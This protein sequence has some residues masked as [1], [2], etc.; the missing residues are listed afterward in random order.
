MILYTLNMFKK[1]GSSDAST[2]SINFKI[3]VK[4]INNCIIFSLLW[5]FISCKIFTVTFIFC[6]KFE[7]SIWFRIELFAIYSKCKLIVIFALIWYSSSSFD[8]LVGG[9]ID[10]V[11]GVFF[12]TYLYNS[13]MCF[14]I[15]SKTGADGIKF[16]LGIF[17]SLSFVS[18]LS[19][20]SGRICWM[21]LKCLL[22]NL[23]SHI[24]DFWLTSSSQ[25]QSLVRTF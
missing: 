1:N 3:F 5:F 23:I 20:L 9:W 21:Y 22:P 18:I 6:A 7:N 17:I 13:M 8:S 11:L 24:A 2:T 16:S 12:I 19:S 4:I 15:P 14:T 25:Y 10:I